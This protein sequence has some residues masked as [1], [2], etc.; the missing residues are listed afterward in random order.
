MNSSRLLQLAALVL[1]LP[2]A[3]VCG[4]GAL[5]V[6]IG[7]HWAAELVGWLQGFTWMRLV[8]SHWIVLGGPMLLVARHAPAVVRLSADAVNEY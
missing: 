7:V 6:V 2:A 8:F 5:Q 4:A 3:A 1:S